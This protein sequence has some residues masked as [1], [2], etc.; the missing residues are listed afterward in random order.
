M[1]TKAKT[2]DLIF[3]EAKLK[4][5]EIFRLILAQQ[6]KK[7][8]GK[9][10]ALLVACE[11]KSEN[12]SEIADILADICEQFGLYC[13]SKEKASELEDLGLLDDK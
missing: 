6:E 12:I 3:E 4:D 2:L 8:T 11:H 7:S 5:G 1:A 9:P 13:I 10:L